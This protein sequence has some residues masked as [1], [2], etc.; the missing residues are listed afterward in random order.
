MEQ[1][2]LLPDL[3]RYVCGA[4]HPSKAMI[5]DQTRIPRWQVCSNTPMRGQRCGNRTLLS[6]KPEKQGL[7]SHFDF[8]PSLGTP[9]RQILCGTL[10]IQRAHHAVLVNLFIC[11]VVLLPINGTKG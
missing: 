5:S 3:I 4:F 7:A 9:R 6:G 8:F 10:H 2:E 11:C 1:Q